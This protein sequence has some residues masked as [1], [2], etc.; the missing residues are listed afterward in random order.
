MPEHPKRPSY[1]GGDTPKSQDR[2]IRKAFRRL[3]IGTIHDTVIRNFRPYITGARPMPTVAMK[4]G[5]GLNITGEPGPNVETVTGFD[6]IGVVPERIPFVKPKLHVAEGETVRRGSLLFT[7]K[8]NP[9]IRFVSPAGGTV[10]AIDFGPRRV[11]RA[12]VIDV[13][14]EEACESVD[15][16]SEKKISAIQK[17]DLAALLMK[18]GLWPFLR[19][20]PFRDMADPS[21]D[22]PAIIVN[23]E[24]LDPFHPG[25]LVYLEG[26]ADFFKLGMSALFRLAPRV[27]VAASP[28]TSTRLTILAPLISHTVTGPYPADDPGVLLYYT[29]TSQADNRSW[30]IHGADVVLLGEF[31]K[32]GCF[33]VHRVVAVSTPTV[34][35]YCR[36]R[37]G[38]P[39]A[40][41]A[42]GL[43]KADTIQ[44]MAGGLW[45]GQRVSAGSFL[46]MYET[47]VTALPDGKTSQF[48]GF[49][50]PGTDK[51]TRSRAFLSRLRKGPL[52]MDA[53]MH[54]EERACVNC[55]TCATVCPVDILPQF[56][57]KAVLAGEVEESLAHG[58]LD[59]VEC[60]LCAYVCPSKIELTEHLKTARQAYYMETTAP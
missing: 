49:L 8:R 18:A 24:A 20:L 50:R 12:I 15:P 42:P 31:L 53:G 29:R 32:T 40:R 57:V 27:M 30:Y 17:S 13:D 44:I 56:T 58:L 37:I 25:P 33:P 26:A 43:D 2:S 14:K 38:A 11:I 23:L 9:D 36:T 6:R 48:L 46:G 16:L 55:G 21:G 35:Y 47:A 3:N 52:P 45:R 28:E 5:L 4:K 10:K 34:R 41:L 1:H 60:G 59:C 54:G 19:A 22:P 39:L 51:P 7:D